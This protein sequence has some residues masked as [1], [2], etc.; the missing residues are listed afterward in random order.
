MLNHIVI[1]GRLTR[2]PEL[3]RTQSGTAVASF[4][5]AVDRDFSGRDGGEK[6]TDFID[7]VAWRQTGEF[8]SKY[9]QKGSMAV[10]SG[11][12]QLRDWQDRDGNKRRS[13]EV[14]VDN[15]YFGESKRQ[16]GESGSYNRDNG[17]YSAPAQSYS[18]PQSGYQGYQS[19]VR[20]SDFEE[21]SDDDGDLPF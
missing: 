1:M 10:V 15:V 4:T 20:G 5:L 7:C 6:Q 19:P 2:D 11:R 9:F 8:V 21:L 12:L 16:S 14:V 18:A 3:R 13:A 17:G